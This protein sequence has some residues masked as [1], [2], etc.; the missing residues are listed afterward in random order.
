[1]SARFFVFNHGMTYEVSLLLLSRIVFHLSFYMPDPESK[2]DNALLRTNVEI[3]IL[4]S[5]S[6]ACALLLREDLR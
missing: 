3:P 4:L 6:H 1:M 2:S 5:T